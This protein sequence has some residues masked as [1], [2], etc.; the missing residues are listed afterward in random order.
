MTEPQGRIDA[1][2]VV[3]LPLTE[4]ERAALAR[5]LEAK[6]AAT[7]AYVVTTQKA[8]AK[9]PSTLTLLRGEHAARQRGDELQATA[10]RVRRLEVQAEL[11]AKCAQADAVH[12]ATVAAARDAYAGDADAH[13]LAIWIETSE[14]GGKGEADEVL[15]M[16]AE[17]YSLG[18]VIDSAEER[19]W[20]GEFDAALQ[21][22][23]DVFNIVD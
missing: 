13:P 1:R 19:E 15:G 4:P 21:D 5:F 8:Y 7:A 11:R 3:K 9:H 10:F 22:A 18:G 12:D 17:G 2:R 6:D 16:L 23:H 20:C 14:H